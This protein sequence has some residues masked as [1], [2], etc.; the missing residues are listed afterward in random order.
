MCDLVVHFLRQVVFSRMRYKLDA[1][2]EQIGADISHFRH[3]YHNRT[4]SSKM[5]VFVTKLTTRPV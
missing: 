3:F 5:A 2:K 1:T 4:K